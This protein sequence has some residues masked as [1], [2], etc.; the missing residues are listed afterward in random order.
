M[1]PSERDMLRGLTADPDASSSE[2]DRFTSLQATYEDTIALR[3][4]T[5]YDD[6]EPADDWDD[7]DA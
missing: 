6:R 4:Q 3:P 1:L 5:R 7:Q 2:P